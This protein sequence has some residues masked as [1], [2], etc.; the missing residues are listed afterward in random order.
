MS[1]DLPGSPRWPRL[2]VGTWAWGDR[3]T[4]GY[5]RAYGRAEVG[6]AFRASLEAGITFFD[7]AEVYGWG[8]S[9]RILGELRQEA[10]RSIQI[11][12]K[13]APFRLTSRALLRALE[14]S[15]AR[16]QVESVDLYQIHF[17]PFFVRFEPL[18]EALAEAALSGKAKAVGVSNFSADQMRRA[19]E[20]LGR[21][22][23]RLAGNQV[24]YSLLHRAPEGD[25]VL[26]ACREL[27]V[28]LIAYSPLAMGLLTGKYHPDGRGQP[29]RLGR[30]L[31]L[32]RP[33]VLRQ[34]IGQLEEIG[35]A[36]SK[37]PSQVALN[38]L[39]RRPEVVVIPGAKNGGQARQNAGALGWEMSIEEAQALD[40]ATQARSEPASEAA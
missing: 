17:P 37:S 20:I 38:W 11:A 15:L 18:L 29:L 27:G 3:H 21:R 10:G 34:V 22:G 6:E 1:Q 4:W 16:L 12:T 25:G 8:T 9:E 32:W 19:H 35:R 36:H 2:G 28:P 30:Y 39:L 33:E 14:G 26:R 23:V 40:R 24:E 7:T 5:N 31:R 13:F